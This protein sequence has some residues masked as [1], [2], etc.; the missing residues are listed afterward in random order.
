MPG[1][2][3]G[4][5]SSLSPVQGAPGCLFDEKLTTRWTG[6]DFAMRPL[7][8]LTDIESLPTFGETG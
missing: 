6:E 5:M 4:S 3:G 8:P 2:G 7:D 1:E